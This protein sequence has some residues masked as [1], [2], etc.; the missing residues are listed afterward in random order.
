[1]EGCLKALIHVP[2]A[3]LQRRTAAGKEANDAL[4]I[5]DQNARR[6]VAPSQ[7][8]RGPVPVPAWVSVPYLYLICIYLAARS[9]AVSAIL[10]IR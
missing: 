8:D 9:T 10:T 5:V 1:M 4:F 7:S 2:A 6:G 3:H